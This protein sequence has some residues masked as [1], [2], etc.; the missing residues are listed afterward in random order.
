MIKFQDPHYNIKLESHQHIYIYIY[1]CNSFIL[2]PIQFFYNEFIS[3]FYEIAPNSG[4][5][6]K[7]QWCAPHKVYCF[8]LNTPITIYTVDIWHI[9]VLNFLELLLITILKLF[10]TK[11]V[12]F[13]MSSGVC[14]FILF[15]LCILGICFL[16]YLEVKEDISCLMIFSFCMYL[17][18][19]II[20][21]W[22][23][24]RIG[25]KTSRCLIKIFINVCWLWL[26]VLLDLCDWY[27]NGDVSC[28]VY[29]KI[30][31]IQY[32]IIWESW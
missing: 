15:L 25:A 14:T 4:L 7:D 19:C 18:S 23:W 3:Y 30:H 28:K 17:L 31:F 8:L 21:D 22:W 6:I 29:S 9:Y 1:I 16:M 11:I 12:I 20:M 24:P 26:E 5:I 13:H 2:S 27:A 10:Y 32:T